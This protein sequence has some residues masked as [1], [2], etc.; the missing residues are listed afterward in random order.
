MKSMKVNTAEVSARISSK[1]IYLPWI[2]VSKN[3]KILTEMEEILHAFVLLLDFHSDRS[4]VVL[5]RACGQKFSARRESLG[6]FGVGRESL[7]HFR[8]WWESL[9]QFVPE[10]L[11]HNKNM[12]DTAGRVRQ[13]R[14]TDICNIIFTLKLWIFR[15]E[16]NVYNII[17][18]NPFRQTRVSAE[19]KQSLNG[20]F[21]PLIELSEA[22]QVPNTHQI[23]STHPFVQIIHQIHR[24]TRT[25]RNLIF[26]GN[27]SCLLRAG[28]TPDSDPCSPGGDTALSAANAHAHTHMNAHAH[29]SFT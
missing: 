16:L 6:Q 15:D 25:S 29:S 10:I 28:Q 14:T 12:T 13:Y 21:S 2:S 20:P 4:A 1:T 27:P 19:R 17:S 5:K 18:P 9:G 11:K 23:H 22:L 24:R 26:T 3:L 7:G 8:V